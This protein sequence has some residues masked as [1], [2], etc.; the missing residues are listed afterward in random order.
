MESWIGMSEK[1]EGKSNEAQAEDG[2]KGKGE[3][4]KK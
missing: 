3:G 1:I 2:G 4:R